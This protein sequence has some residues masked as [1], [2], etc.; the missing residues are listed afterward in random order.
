MKTLPLYLVRTIFAVELSTGKGRLILRH[1][2]VVGEKGNNS[3]EEL[4]KSRTR[5]RISLLIVST[6]IVSANLK[7]RHGLVNN[8][9]Y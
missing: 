9:T 1:F 7:M 3:G 6:E 4:L 5:C 8:K 2:I